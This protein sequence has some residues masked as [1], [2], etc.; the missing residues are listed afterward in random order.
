MKTHT[1]F[2]VVLSAFAAPAMATTFIAEYVVASAP[3]A[4]ASGI[5]QVP[6]LSP[7]LYVHVVDGTVNLTNKGGSQAFASGQFGYASSGQTPPAL[8]PA[9]AGLKFTL[10]P[11][12]SGQ[13]S[14]NSSTAEKSGSVDC[15]VR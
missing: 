6:L 12:L 10:P 14:S 11:T 1:L 5:V 8:V 3:R 13:M 9:S 15:T 2:I 7:G 4:A